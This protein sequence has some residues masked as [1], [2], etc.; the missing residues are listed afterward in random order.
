M[1][2]LLVL[3][4][5]DDPVVE[6][7]DTE[8]LI[9][10]FPCPEFELPQLDDSQ[11]T[12]AGEAAGGDILSFAGEDPLYALSVMSGLYRSDDGGQ[13]WE[14]LLVESTHGAGQM[15]VAPNGH[16]YVAIARG[17]LFYSNNGE[18]FE[19][20][21]LDDNESN[22]IRGLVVHNGALY[23]LD[24]R[25]QLWTGE[26]KDWSLVG[27]LS[28]P[29]PPHGN[30]DNAFYPDTSWVYLGSNGDRMFGLQHQG[31]LL[32]SDNDGVDW[33]L[34]REGPFEVS[35]FGVEGPHVY[36]YAP[37]EG[38]VWSND[39]GE[40]FVVHEVEL[41]L[42]G[43]RRHDGQLVGVGAETLVTIG[44]ASQELDLHEGFALHSRGEEGLLIGHKDGIAT[45]QDGQL[46]HASGVTTRDLGPL[47]THPE[48]PSRVWVGTQCERGLFS[49]I[50]YGSSF[51]RVDEYLHYVMVPVISPSDPATMWVTSD[52][53]LVR[54]TNLGGSWEYILR[55][56]LT[57]H[58]HGVAVH[59]SD[60]DVVLIGT[61]GSG[62]A[63]DLNGMRV[64]RTTD[65]GASWN[66]ASEGLPENSHAS[67]HGFHFVNDEVVILGTFRGGD[68]THTG[69]TP[70]VGLYRS[71]DAGLSWTRVGP[72]VGDA[73]VITSCGERVWAATDGGVLLSEDEG[74]TWSVSRAGDFLS[75]ACHG[76]IVLAVSFDAVDRSDD[77]GASWYGWDNGVDRIPVTRQMPQVTISRD[78]ELAY[79]ALPTGGL[80]RRPL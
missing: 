4:C 53:T 76:E 10:E 25:G 36:A 18:F 33:S 8:A 40:S 56:E 77:G 28:F 70:G 35:T 41:P 13:S 73:A 80:Y 49:S 62:E 68:Y 45:L 7:G 57:W 6:T 5:A 46:S 14:H 19:N 16:I 31:D 32:V 64:L 9:A 67:A 69:D 61:V 65:G 60:D 38:V 2:L 3:S 17:L 43:L 34:L 79:V 71:D 11:W 75:V 20:T 29:P 63:L 44:E 48:C 27:T 50:D 12:R 54:T 78:G 30:E 15:V 52:D 39:G 74:E 22:Q 1:W 21:T 42:N 26:A 37:N 66:D 51:T 47:V 58:L 24:H 72:E 23:A 55:D 59:P